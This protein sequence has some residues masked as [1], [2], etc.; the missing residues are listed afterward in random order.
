M[1][2]QAPLDHKRP[3]QGRVSAL[4]PVAQRRVGRLDVLQAQLDES[5]RRH[6]VA[7]LQAASPEAAPAAVPGRVG[8]VPNRT[9]LPDQLKAGIERLSGIAM[10]NVRVHYGSSQPAQLNAHA[11]AQ[12]A[13]IHLAPGQAHHL[14]HEAW[15][16]VQQAQGRVRPTQQLQAKNVS[17]NDDAHL[18]RE[19]DIM[20]ARA[21]RGIAA[22]PVSAALDHRAAPTAV[23]QPMRR[24]GGSLLGSMPRGSGGGGGKPPSRPFS[25]DEL[26][27]KQAEAQA[28][29][30]RQ[31][32]EREAQQRQRQ[33][34]QR[35]IQE[36][37]RRLREQQSR[38]QEEQRRIDA[39]Q[40]QLQQQRERAEEEAR[41][42][43]ALAANLKRMA[44]LLAPQRSSLASAHLDESPVNS[45][46]E[47]AESGTTLYRSD[48]YPFH[49]IQPKYGT[50][51]SVLRSDS[52]LHPV[53]PNGPTTPALHVHGKPEDKAKSP[54][55][56]T[57]T[58]VESA[59]PYGKNLIEFMPCP[60]NFSASRKFR[61]TSSSPG[62]PGLPK[63]PSTSRSLAS[64]NGSRQR[65][66][67]R[68][69][70]YIWACRLMA[71]ITPTDSAGKSTALP[72]MRPW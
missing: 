64:R 43:R 5:P 8:P 51:K 34:R 63:R 49:D 53:D 21:M 18:E 50:F 9:G 26:R 35:Q 16:V 37:Q 59:S 39:Q 19:A 45:S 69:A 4:Q 62:I 13:D 44:A 33:E 42:R 20:G 70:Q 55:T 58:K 31:R 6:A 7:Q 72:T 47:G 24:A 66:P 36:Q 52:V 11:F 68:Q 10:D 61:A 1:A 46:T 71:A 48:D 12:G 67:I 65:Q 28:A 60:A 57:S 29:A 27:K 22:A 41:A 25:F 15:H 30:A 23:L 38:F 14:P 40:R 54:Y 17:I 56:S 2:E 32:A 3:R